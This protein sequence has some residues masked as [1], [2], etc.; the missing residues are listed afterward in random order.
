MTNSVQQVYSDVKAILPVVSNETG[1]VTVVHARVWQPGTAARP[2]TMTWAALGQGRIGHQGVVMDVT[3]VG[4]VV[5]LPAQ[6]RRQDGS[7]IIEVLCMAPD[8]QARVAV[9]SGRSPTEPP[10]E[11]T[12]PTRGSSLLSACLE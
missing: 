8:C 10:T 7:A 3:H 9:R 11:T 2:R 5:S 12:Q 6:G 4:P 1:F